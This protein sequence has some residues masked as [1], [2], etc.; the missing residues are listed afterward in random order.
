M[1]KGRLLGKGTARG[2]GAGA[3][4][5]LSALRQSGG[6]FPWP[7]LKDPPSHLL[8]HVAQSEDR[9]QGLGS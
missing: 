1:E 8:G 2:Q 4:G 9:P 3:W 5:R 7:S 6:I